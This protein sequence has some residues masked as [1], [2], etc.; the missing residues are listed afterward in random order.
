MSLK[1]APLAMRAACFVDAITFLAATTLNLGAKIPLEHPGAELPRP[2]LT[3]GS[4]RSRNR[5]RPARG[6]AERAGRASLGS[7]LDVMIAFSLS[8]TRV[9][10]PSSRDPHHTHPSRGRPLQADVA[11]VGA[12]PAC[13]APRAETHAIGAA[14]SATHT[15]NSDEE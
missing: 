7:F 12:P 10:G 15:G 1:Q 14:R 6:R 4:R 2:D 3:G 9:Q 11:Q 8:S 13:R 5:T